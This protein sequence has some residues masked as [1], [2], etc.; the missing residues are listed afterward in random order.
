M[1][2]VKIKPTA[3]GPGGLP[4]YTQ[5][6]LA[7]VRPGLDYKTYITYLTRKRAALKTPGTVDNLNS[8]Y[9]NAVGGVLSPAQLAAMQAKQTAQI[10]AGQR[11]AIADQYRNEAALANQ[12][13][14][15]ALGTSQATMKAQNEAGETVARMNAGLLQ[16]VNDRYGSAA[17]ALNDLATSTT[18]GL[19]ADVAANTARTN[20]ALAALNQ[21]GI[22]NV[23]PG[24]EQPGV[25]AYQTGGLGS[26]GLT[27]LGKDQSF[28][29]AGLINAQLLGANQQAIANQQAAN[30]AAG[31]T[32][33]DALA[34][35]QRT[36]TAATMEMI[37][38][39]PGIAAQILNQLQT[40]NRQQIALASS[41]LQQELAAKQAAFTRNL[42]TKQ[43]NQGV[44]TTA[45]QLALAKSAQEL[46]GKRLEQQQNQWFQNQER[47]IKQFNAG[48]VTAAAKLGLPNAALSKA[49][50][51]L[52]DSNGKPIPDANGNLRILPGF[53][54]DPK[55]GQV[56]KVSTTQSVNGAPSTAAISK[57]L[58]T[59]QPRPTYVTQTRKTAQGSA[60]RKVQTGVTYPVTYQQA[61]KRLT[62]WGKLSDKDARTYLQSIYPRGAGGRAWLTNEEQNA[63]KQALGWDYGR[64]GVGQVPEGWPGPV[65]SVQPHLEKDPKGVMHA[66]LSREQVW[67]L[68]QAKLLPPG[69]TGRL[70]DGTPIYFINATV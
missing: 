53:R 31:Q 17:A 29:L 36:R 6:Q 3:I 23:M 14:Q 10:I 12:A 11:Q 43:F 47:L 45:A 30:L 7:Q 32:Q 58:G 61:Y 34:Q 51:M 49:A 70:T 25:L 39:Q 42:Q 67:A 52:V 9:Q 37:K 20:A 41:L 1:A 48:Q 33:A 4:T 55:T 54:Y 66:Y 40:A 24:P 38:N 27:A 68:Q 8:L 5:A 60:S 62:T 63:L 16:N 15:R 57:Y 56:V 21:P 26:Q 18:Q 35:A 44:K 13:Y 69:H 50:G 59:L 65:R 19:G 28:G 46:T 22:D 64:L 2:P